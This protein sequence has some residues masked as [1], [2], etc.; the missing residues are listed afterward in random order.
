VIINVGFCK[1]SV[2]LHIV[3]ARVPPGKPAKRLLMRQHRIKKE[4]DPA[5]TSPDSEP[6]SP[7]FTSGSGLLSL[8]P[9]RIETQC[10]EPP[11]CSSP[12]LQPNPATPN[13]LT[14]PQ[15][16]FLVKQHSHPLL[17]SQQSPTAPTPTS[18][19]VQRQLSQPAPGQTCLVPPP[20]PSLHVHLVATPVQ[21][22][23]N[24]EPTSRAVSPSVVIEQ[25]PVLRVVTDQTTTDTTKSSSHGGLRVRSDELRRASSSPQVQ[26]HFC[27]Y[28]KTC[29][30]LKSNNLPLVRVKHEIKVLIFV[31]PWLQ[32]H[33]CPCLLSP[34]HICPNLVHPPC[35]C[36]S[37]RPLS[38]W[39]NFYCHLGYSVFICLLHLAE[40]QVC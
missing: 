39:F 3:S 20:P 38:F 37:H 7:H 35:S 25:L 14:V 6:G 9:V 10:S 32:V 29:S 40:P 18:L 13:L 19:L 33:L 30:F 12:T 17:P 36:A 23:P 31:L 21:P 22:P 11:P 16:T 5:H 28:N 27:M 4:C 15:P 8:P 1:C 2:W 34:F 24:Q 26:L